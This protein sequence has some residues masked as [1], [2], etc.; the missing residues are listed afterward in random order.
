[1]G[2][3]GYQPAVIFGQRNKLTAEGPFLKMFSV[4]QNQL[5]EADELIVIGYSFR[6]IHINESIADWFNYGSARKIT[7]VDPNQQWA[8]QSDF[9]GKL[10]LA[11]SGGRVRYI[12]QTAAQAIPEL[13]LV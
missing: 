13:F 11:S 7:V 2:K 8:K 6:D 1:M 12:A 5:A 3:R 4:F 10:G 9:A